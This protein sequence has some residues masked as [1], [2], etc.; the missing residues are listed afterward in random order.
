MAVVGDLIVELVVLHLNRTE[1][2]VEMELHTTL[3]EE[4]VV[5]AEA[6]VRMLLKLLG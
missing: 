4:V 5:A 2:L 6:W 3:K 1:N